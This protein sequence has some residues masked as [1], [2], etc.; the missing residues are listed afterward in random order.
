[1][2]SVSPAS[3]EPYE[4]VQGT[5]PV[6]R[7]STNNASSNPYPPPPSTLAARVAAM[8]ED[9]LSQDAYRGLP[10]QERSAM[11]THLLGVMYPAEL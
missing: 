5:P 3:P 7:R 11:R 2:A 9:M 1:M 6:R 8:V 4:S 10:S